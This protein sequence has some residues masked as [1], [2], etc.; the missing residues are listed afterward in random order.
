MD[1]FHRRSDPRHRIPTMKW[2][3]RRRVRAS[4]K[5]D[6][7]LQ[8]RNSAAVGGSLGSSP[9]GRGLRLLPRSYL[10][11]SRETLTLGDAR[12]RIAFDRWK[13]RFAG[14]INIGLIDPSAKPER[15]A[16]YFHPASATLG[17]APPEMAV[18]SAK[19]DPHP[20]AWH[21]PCESI[22]D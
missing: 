11:V 2:L 19:S 13:H 10:R 21:V 6:K 3:S 1:S 8:L 16:I 18:L 5:P 20:R 14:P 15:T 4:M 12:S 22:H 17:A 7:S 9:K